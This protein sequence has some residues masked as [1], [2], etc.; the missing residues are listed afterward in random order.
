MKRQTIVVKKQIAL[1]CIV[2]AVAFVIMGIDINN[3]YNIDEKKFNL[4]VENPQSNN[5]LTNSDQSN[6]MISTNFSSPKSTFDSEMRDILAEQNLRDKML[7]NYEC[8]SVI[9]SD[10]VLYEDVYKD[11]YNYLLRSQNNEGYEV[12]FIS[13][14]GGSI[15]SEVYGALNIKID[16]DMKCTIET[17]SGAV[18]IDA[19]PDSGFALASYQIDGT[20]TRL[21][22]N[23]SVNYLLDDVTIKLNYS[24]GQALYDKT[25]NSITLSYNK[26]L[27][28]DNNKI[29]FGIEEN[30]DAT[31]TSSYAPQ[32]YYAGIRP[33]SFCIDSNFNIFHPV[34]TAGYFGLLKTPNKDYVDDTRVIS[35][36]QYI[37]YDETCNT[38]YMFNGCNNPYLN[39]EFN[40]KTLGCVKNTTGMFSYSNLKFAD[41]CFNNVVYAGFMFENCNNLKTINV[42][43]W[44]LKDVI[45][46]QSMFYR[47]GIICLEND[48]QFELGNK[49]KYL[50]KM[51]S[52]CKNLEELNIE[53]L[54]LNGLTYNSTLYNFVADSINLKNISFKYWNWSI[55]SNKQNDNNPKYILFKNNKYMQSITIPANWWINLKDAGL[56]NPEAQFV[57]GA[58]GHWYESFTNEKYLNNTIPLNTDIFHIYVAAKP[59]EPGLPKAVYKQ[60]G[61]ENQLVFYYD[62]NSH[63]GE[64]QAWECPEDSEG[65][66]DLPWDNVRRSVNRVLIDDSFINWKDAKSYACW[67]EN[68]ENAYFDNFDKF[69][70]TSK[71]TNL[72]KLFCRCSKISSINIKNFNTSNVTIMEQMFALCSGLTSLDLSN[73]NTENV[74]TMYQMFGFCNKLTSL[75]LSNFDTYSVTDMRL[76]FDNCN[77]LSTL[78]IKNFD[79]S[80]VVYMGKMFSNCHSLSYLDLT[81]FD[82]RNVKAMNAMFAYCWNL[83]SVDLSSFTFTVNTKIGGVSDDIDSRDDGMFVYCSKLKYIYCNKD[84]TKI[85]PL[86]KSYW[87]FAYTSLPNIT[88]G[89]FSWGGDLAK[90]SSNG[91]VFTKKNSDKIYEK[92][93]K[94]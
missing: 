66:S 28:I 2:C 74:T 16:S 13:N 32:Y 35:G 89:S 27:D 86:E 69:P 46:V 23:N 50:S 68:F 37:N 31:D 51:F 83:V 12:K 26:N 65:A 1:L 43:N 18:E 94:K 40:N 70:C 14:S 84:I 45:N 88:K 57:S 53:N 38:S 25:N 39:L 7:R 91:G 71:V 77:S 34:S 5:C 36:L 21:L 33:I 60:L 49:V 47:S 61:N 42:D 58:D 80:H 90:P 24:K 20:K 6:Q 85:I 22:A 76:M 62:N 10:K 30:P 19:L 73:L 72:Y 59:L 79:T 48:T 44:K 54:L 29:L 81:N 9:L 8:N 52:E 63:E 78:N 4:E 41:I 75:D 11:K 82:T 56:H 87:A 67:F 55:N 93:Q 15:P 3:H 64:G 17:I 92:T